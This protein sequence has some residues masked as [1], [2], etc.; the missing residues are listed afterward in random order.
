MQHQYTK[1]TVVL[2]SQIWCVMCV[3]SLTGPG[4]PQLLELTWL[5]MNCCAT[6]EE[7]N[8]RDV[9]GVSY[10]GHGKQTV[11][12]THLIWLPVLAR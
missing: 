9:T 2:H 3:A 8:V 12:S 11:L 4:T 7:H 1:P 10:P 6:E 5:M